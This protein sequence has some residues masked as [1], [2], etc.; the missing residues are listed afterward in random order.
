MT[1]FNVPMRNFTEGFP[2]SN[3]TLL[4]GPNGQ[5]VTAWFAFNLDGYLTLQAPYA[6][7]Q[8]QFAFYVDDGAILSLDGH[9]VLNFDGY[10]SPQW[11]CQSTP[12]TLNLGEKHPMNLK[13]F[14]G[15]PTQLALR[16]LIRPVQR[17]SSV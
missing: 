5:A 16:V 12:M 15:P 10:H 1:N 2:L 9:E 7:G 17:N 4:K 3:G 6:S 11:S 8:Y 13:Y 14:Q